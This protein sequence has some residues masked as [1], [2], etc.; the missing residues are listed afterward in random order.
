MT[1]N[2]ASAGQVSKSA[3]EIY[4]EFFVPALFGPWAGPLCDAVGVGSG[5][6]VLDIACGTGA[7][8]REAAE[9]VGPGGRVVGLDRNRGMLDVARRRAPDMEWIEGLAEALPFTGGTF[10]RVLCQFALMFFDQQP[11]A[12]AE[13]ARV[14]RPGGR[15]AL[16]VWDDV[17]RSPGYAGMIELIQEM[18]GQDA[19][20]ALRAPFVLGDKSVLLRVLEDGGLAGAELTSVAGTARFASIRDWVRTDVRGWTLGDFMDDAGFEALVAAAEQRLR[21]FAA[22]DGSVA[23]P[24]PAHVVV[25]RR[26]SEEYG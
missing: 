17:A 12:L 22:S 18:F 6:D 25:W 10:D 8:T 21:G 11:K 3:A 1:T 14:V 19:A 15:I 16:T 2:A 23:F 4:D 13:M 26:K 24:A 20:D 5:Q 7:T 9:R